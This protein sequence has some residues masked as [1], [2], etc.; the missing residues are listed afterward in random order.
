MA[1][2]CSIAVAT[3]P[4]INYLNTGSAA[5]FA[6][7]LPFPGTS[8]G[9]N[10][11]NIVVLVTGQVVIPEAGPWTF[12]VN[13]DDGFSLELTRVVSDSNFSETSDLVG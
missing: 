7:D 9:T 11:D 2:P 10:V 13:S 3:A 5:H 6:G 4:T 8:I 1:A 12:G